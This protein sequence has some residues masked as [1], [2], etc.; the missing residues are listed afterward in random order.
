MNSWKEYERIEYPPDTAFSKTVFRI[1]R[2][3]PRNDPEEDNDDTVEPQSN[4]PFEF[5]PELDVICQR[6]LT[7]GVPPLSFDMDLALRSWMAPRGP[8]KRPTKPGRRNSCTFPLATLATHGFVRVSPPG[9][10]QVTAPDGQAAE[11]CPTWLPTLR[12]LLIPKFVRRHVG[13]PTSPLPS[14]HCTICYDK[15]QIAGVTEE[16]IL[17]EQQRGETVER[18]P[19]ALLACGHIVGKNCIETFRQAEVN[20]DEFPQ[21]PECRFDLMPEGC[22]H[23][24]L[25]PIQDISQ[26]IHDYEFFLLWE[27]ILPDLDTLEE[28][29][30]RGYA[31]AII[32]GTLHTEE[33]TPAN[34]Y[35]AF[36]DMVQW[37]K[38]YN[39]IINKR[40]DEISDGLVKIDKEYWDFGRPVSYHFPDVRLPQGSGGEDTRE[41]ASETRDSGGDAKQDKPMGKRSRG[42]GEEEAQGPEA[43][44]ARLDM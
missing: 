31:S 15:L 2:P 24:G 9:P 42:E 10:H 37:R 19:A 41:P 38:D 28:A 40:V 29:F 43:K 3:P 36:M 34:W 14:P 1:P 33:I 22:W 12:K 16:E 4:S 20:A 44:K 17:L 27:H 30:E 35:Q 39:K 6:A 8:L 26:S 21:C 18:E 32:D 5:W 23:H 13:V 11:K 7:R 25:I